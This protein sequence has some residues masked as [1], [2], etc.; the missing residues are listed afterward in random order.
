VGGTGD[1][2]DALHSMAH[3]YQTRLDLIRY[4]VSQL[5]RLSRG[6][7][8]ARRHRRVAQTH[9][10]IDESCHH[11]GHDGDNASAAG[12]SKRDILFRT[13]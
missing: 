7:V 11:L 1:A 13:T 2:V 5:Q 6:H 9:A 8:H 4:I 10:R 12:Q 3:P